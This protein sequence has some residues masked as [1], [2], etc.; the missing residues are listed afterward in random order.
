M[1]RGAR[2]GEGNNVS[3]SFISSGT[4][5]EAHASIRGEAMKKD[6]YVTRTILSS[7]LTPPFD[8]DEEMKSRIAKASE[9][10][11]PGRDKASS[12]DCDGEEAAVGGEA[13]EAASSSGKKAGRSSGEKSFTGLSQKSSR[14]PKLG[15]RDVFFSS[16]GE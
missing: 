15:S 11:D 16:E 13:V 3:Y 4:S 2:G 6:G 14:H 5:E 1:G 12:G 8:F 7:Q 9:A 10:A